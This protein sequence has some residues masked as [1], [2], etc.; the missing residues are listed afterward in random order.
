[1]SM[2]RTPRGR[3]ASSTALIG[4]RRRGHATAFAGALD[5]Q[6]IGEARLLIER[7]REHGQ[8][9]CPRQRVIHEAG[10]DELAA[11]VV[12]HALAE[13]LAKPLG[14][15]AMHLAVDDERIDQAA[16]IVD[17]GVTVD[18]DLAGVGIDLHLT[19][20]TAVGKP[21][22]LGGEIRA[23]LQGRREGVSATEQDGMSIWR[24]PGG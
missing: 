22:R 8:P 16:E 6:R 14:E 15:G 12:D 9:A 17:C 19:D 2:W 18:G 21:W 5:A 1:M 20:V 23:C 3:S 4:R 10:G 7:D 13:R 11:V 24:C